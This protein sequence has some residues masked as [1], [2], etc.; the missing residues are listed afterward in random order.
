[1]QRSQVFDAIDQR[2][3]LPTVPEPLCTA[4]CTEAFAILVDRPL[5]PT[6]GCLRL[7]CASEM[8]FGPISCITTARS[9]PDVRGRAEAGPAPVPQVGVIVGKDFIGHNI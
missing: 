3:F 4:V 6:D 8:D 9:A 5:R 1:M 2:Q 7:I